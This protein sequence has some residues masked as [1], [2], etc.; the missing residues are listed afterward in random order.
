MVD[1]SQSKIVVRSIPI[2]EETGAFEELQHERGG[3]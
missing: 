2:I 1:K 3:D